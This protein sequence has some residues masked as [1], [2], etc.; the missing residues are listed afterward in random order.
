[1][2]GKGQCIDPM[3]RMMM[4]SVSPPAKLPALTLADVHKHCVEGD[5]WIA[6]HGKVYD[7][8]KF[9]RF[10]PG[11]VSSLLKTA[12]MDGTQ[13]FD[14]FH[15]WVDLDDILGCCVV[16]VLNCA[17][18]ETACLEVEEQDGDANLHEVWSLL[19][20]AHTG[21]STLERVQSFLRSVGATDQTFARFPIFQ[22]PPDATVSFADFKSIV[23]NL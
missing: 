14:K 4:S 9:L 17:K 22:C 7:C 21:H 6:L 8:S 5:L 19:D 13:S 15:S 2:P 1:M 11:G 20:E 16:G 23:F 3:W 12:G 10:H 18:E